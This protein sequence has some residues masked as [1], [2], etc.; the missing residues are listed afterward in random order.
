MSRW[1]EAFE[2]YRDAVAALT[3]AG[4]TDEDLDRVAPRRREYFDG[5]PPRVH[6]PMACLF[7]EVRAAVDECGSWEAFIEAAAAAEALAV[8]NLPRAGYEIRAPSWHE[9][10]HSWRDP[11]GG[12]FYYC[13]QDGR[14]L[15]PSGVIAYGH[16][17]PP[18]T[19][20]ERPVER[21]DSGRCHTCRFWGDR[22][23]SPAIVVDESNGRWVYS[24]GGR[25]STR[26]KSHLGF[27]GR[28]W[29]LRP[30]DGG[31]EVVDTNNLWTS[32]EVPDAWLDDF[33]PTHEHDHG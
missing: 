19:K 16:L 29:R 9:T 7:A 14:N 8:E 31:G 2:S 5:D 32:G 12:P 6:V 33:P 30:L 18:C 11:K 10:R 26:D 24:D 1:D 22:L 20:C 27:G 15:A 3:K 13:D 21:G 4:A 23:R 25:R 28:E 17:L